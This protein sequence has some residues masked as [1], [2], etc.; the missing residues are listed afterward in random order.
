M[1]AA[2]T[3]GYSPRDLLQT[4]VLV[5]DYRCAGE[6]LAS[7]PEESLALASS[8]PALLASYTPR[9][10]VWLPSSRRS[11]KGNFRPIRECAIPQV[12][13]A[14]SRSGSVRLG[15]FLVEGPASR[16]G[17][18]LLQSLGVPCGCCLLSLSPSHSPPFP[19]CPLHPARLRYPFVAH[20]S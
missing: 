16:P 12:S 20:H 18:R 19:P 10:V 4:S 14:A 6:S 2:L 9:C 13:G 17:G 5:G 3:S 7:G 11:A 8:R 1:P 15:G